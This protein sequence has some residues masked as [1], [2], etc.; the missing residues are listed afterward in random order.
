MVRKQEGFEKLELANL[1]SM[2]TVDI[3]LAH[4]EIPEGQVKGMAV[5]INE[6]RDGLM[7]KVCYVKTGDGR[8]ISTT[9]NACMMAI[10]SALETLPG[11]SIRNGEY[12]YVI[13]ERSQRGSKFAVLQFTEYQNHVKN[14]LHAPKDVAVGKGGFNG[15]TGKNSQ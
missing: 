12:G 13:L 14:P 15:D 2:E 4:E 9:A 11:N 5:V 3:K 1:A 10:E 7:Q 6:D 8:I